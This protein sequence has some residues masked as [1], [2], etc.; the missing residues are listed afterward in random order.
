[1]RAISPIDTRTFQLLK[2]LKAIVLWSDECADQL[3]RDNVREAKRC[4]DLIH[5]YATQAEMIRQELAP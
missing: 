5:L 4:A 2:Y 1:M 3:D